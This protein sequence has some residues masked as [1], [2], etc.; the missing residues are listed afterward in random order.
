M[1]VHFYIVNGESF[2]Q[3][4]PPAP[5]YDDILYYDDIGGTG[6]YH[7]VEMELVEYLVRHSQEALV[8]GSYH[9]WLYVGVK[10]ANFDHYGY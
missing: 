6:Q 5:G 7:T 1:A 10:G 9:C 4:T 2:Q 8:V 3:R